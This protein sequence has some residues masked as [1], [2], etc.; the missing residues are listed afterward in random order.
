MSWL[1]ICSADVASKLK[2][3]TVFF[4]SVSKNTGCK[5]AVVSFKY[6]SMRDRLMV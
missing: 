5:T 2:L 1:N 6:K 3:V 4:V